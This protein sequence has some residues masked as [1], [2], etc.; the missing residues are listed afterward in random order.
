[1]DDEKKLT[2]VSCFTAPMYAAV[3]FGELETFCL[4][5]TL[6][7]SVTHVSL[8]LHDARPGCSVLLWLF[9]GVLNI[10]NWGHSL[11]ALKSR[12]SDLLKLET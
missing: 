1:M 4:I 7:I 9:V 3:L 2:I 5:R 10:C 6:S 12:Q 8:V 11:L